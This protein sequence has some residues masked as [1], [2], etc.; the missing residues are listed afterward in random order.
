MIRSFA[1]V[2]LTALITLPVGAASAEESPA[3]VIAYEDPALER[4]ATRLQAE[5]K[6]AGRGPVFLERRVPL[7]SCTSRAPRDGS[8]GQV[9]IVLR[10]EE[11]EAVSAEICA[12][13]RSN[14]LTV[15][16]ARGRIDER[17][18]FSIVVTEA[19][20]GVLISPQTR[21]QSVGEVEPPN[22][23]PDSEKEAEQS[24]RSFPGSLAIEPRLSLDVPTGGAWVGLTP[25]LRVPL[26]G[27][28]HFGAEMF[29]GLDPIDYSDAQIELESHLVWARFGLSGA[30]PL[31]PVLLAWQ[32]AAGP[33]SN[34]ATA[35]AVPPREGGSDGTFG[36]I[37]HAGALAEL[38]ARGRFF[39]RSSIG[40]STLVPR[41][42][43]QMSD[44]VTPEVG[45][46]L[47]EGGL[48]VG[49]RFGL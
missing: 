7:G 32:I 42:R 36:A 25:T 31:G 6:S 45:Q 39:V 26:G 23:T 48:G 49:I 27:G 40:A 19:L 35:E 11:N 44:D 12:R 33:Y 34:R 17:A 47:L 38:P 4:V 43:Y 37:V 8:A 41:L 28:L 10:S 14:Q 30:K 1:A 22:D 16:T 46:L 21:A 3:V 29:L 24:A 5:L 15:V 9:G 13:P 18:D 2:F 20:H